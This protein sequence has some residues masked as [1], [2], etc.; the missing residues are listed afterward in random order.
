MAQ[1]IVATGMYRVWIGGKPVLV[2]P[3]DAKNYA[4]LGYKVER[5]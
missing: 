4:R 3:S 2:A 5:I 1:S